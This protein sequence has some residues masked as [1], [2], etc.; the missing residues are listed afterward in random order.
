VT[1][2]TYDLLRRR[3]RLLVRCNIGVDA[4]SDLI[5]S[6]VSTAANV[7]ELNIPADRLHGGVRL[8]YGDADHIGI[9]KLEEFQDGDA[10]FWIAM[11][12]GQRRVL[13]EPAGGRFRR[14]TNEN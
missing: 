11:K 14:L 9:E 2:I 7:H 10:E 4:A 12:R 6:V 8:V 5:H 13:P 1:Q 3:L